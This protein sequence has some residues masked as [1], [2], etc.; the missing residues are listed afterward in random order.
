MTYFFDYPVNFL[1]DTQRNF[2]RDSG[3]VYRAFST[4]TEGDGTQSRGETAY[5]F[6]TYPLYREGSLNRLSRI[7]HIF[8]IAS[9][10]TNYT[11]SVPTGFGTGSNVTRTLP[12]H[13][14]TPQG[15]QVPI[16][17]DGK[18]HDLFAVPTPF[19]V[20]A[21]DIAFT[22][23]GLRIY[24]VMLLDLKLSL[25]ADSRFTQ[26]VPK[27]VNRDTGVFEG[28]GGSRWRWQN[29]A[30]WKW[31]VALGARF[32]GTESYD[33][34]VALIQKQTVFTFAQEYQRYPERIY[35]AFFKNDE[36]TLA[37]ISRYKGAG[38]EL[39]FEV[40]EM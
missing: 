3:N 27:L 31:E 33:A 29:R 13:V 12:E 39:F 8:V 2:A 18:Q 40:A 1:S 9:G 28:H 24:C 38:T 30:A 16:L 21:L 35:P 7:S 4:F 36:T 34:L 32:R 26:I 20:R 25:N 23:S 22:G 14:T 17:H 5:R 15:Q 6:Y 37:Y 10:V 19:T 11:V